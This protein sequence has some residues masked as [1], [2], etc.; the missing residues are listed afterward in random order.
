MIV[1]VKNCF[2]TSN[3]FYM[4]S[5]Q[6]TANTSV[7]GWFALEARSSKVEVKNTSVFTMHFETLVEKHRKHVLLRIL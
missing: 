1:L 5:C 2:N 3:M 6:N 4:L 7:F